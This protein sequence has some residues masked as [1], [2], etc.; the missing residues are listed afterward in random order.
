MSGNP[1][2]LD[3]AWNDHAPPAA[4]YIVNGPS[5]PTQTNNASIS[6]FVHGSIGQ[7]FA[8]G[9][10]QKPMQQYPVTQTALS[11]NR[12]DGDERSYKDRA[13]YE[14]L[15]KI[16]EMFVANEEFLA[17]KMNEVQRATQK[18]TER[19]IKENTVT[20]SL[21]WLSI[22]IVCIVAVLFVTY[23]AMEQCNFKKLMNA[24]NRAQL[25][26]VDLKVLYPHLYS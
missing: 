2:S 22:T 3:D 9:A 12:V 1:V 10:Q 21:D 4:Q 15:N 6:N 17:Q 14:L 11:V 8:H 5:A 13:Q 19:A 18:H 7:A 25:K 16:S 20:P 26:S 24:I 23:V